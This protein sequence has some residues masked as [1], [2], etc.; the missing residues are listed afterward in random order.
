MSS[1]AHILVVDDDDSIRL[2]VRRVLEKAG[3][4]VAEAGTGLDALK[5]IDADSF[6]LVI[7]DINM[8]ELDGLSLVEGLR[9]NERTR[10]VP[11]IFITASED[12]A[13]FAKSVGL[14]ARHFLNK[15]FSTE[16]L[17]EKV[18]QALGR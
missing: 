1:A 8:P 14:K 2:L 13:L 5:L 7:S 17:V 4:R 3:H 16:K 6:D 10:A 11:V 12:P 15:P 9:F 18:T